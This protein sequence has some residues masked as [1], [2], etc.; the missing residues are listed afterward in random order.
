[1]KPQRLRKQQTN[2]G[3]DFVPAVINAFHVGIPKVCHV[4]S[5][6]GPHFRVPYKTNNPTPKHTQYHY[7][8]YLFGCFLLGYFFVF[9]FLEFLQ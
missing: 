3:S 1:M 7:I 2:V 4:A 5:I 9:L 6:P 8:T